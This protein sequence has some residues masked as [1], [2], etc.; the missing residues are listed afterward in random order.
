ME[1]KEK[2]CSIDSGRFKEIIETFNINSCCE[3]CY[4]FNPLVTDPGKGYRCKTSPACIADTLHPNLQSYLW[5]KLGWIEEAEH[6]C[7]IGLN[8]PSVKRADL[9]ETAEDRLAKINSLLS[10]VEEVRKT[11]EGKLIISIVARSGLAADLMVNRLAKLLPSVYEYTVEYFDFP[12]SEEDLR[13]LRGRTRALVL[14]QLDI[15]RR[16]LSASTEA[17]AD[18]KAFLPS[19]A[20]V[21]RKLNLDPAEL[22]I[23]FG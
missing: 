13:H 6:H 12:L 20:T 9:L 14:V 1:L 8:Q 16:A 7:N 19:L 21:G 10:S 11:N 5:L 18:L 22:I 3:K 4:F 2:L 17:L 15:N 23:N